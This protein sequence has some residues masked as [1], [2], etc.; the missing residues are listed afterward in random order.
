MASDMASDC[1]LASAS[2]MA[3]VFGLPFGEKALASETY[4][5]CTRQLQNRTD[6]L[7]CS[8]KVRNERNCNGIRSGYFHKTSTSQNRQSRHQ[9]TTKRPQDGC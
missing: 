5:A 2:D 3:S 4:N 8:S 7:R 1:V 9:D 6:S